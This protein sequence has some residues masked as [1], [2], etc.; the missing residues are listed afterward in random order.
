MFFGC[1]TGMMQHRQSSSVA[2]HNWLTKLEIT[3]PQRYPP[4]ICLDY[5]EFKLELKKNKDESGV[6]NYRPVPRPEVCLL[7]YLLLELLLL[8][9]Y[10]L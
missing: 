6:Y 4:I 1:G 5:K 3:N 10:N 7:L 9:F 8:I 2:G